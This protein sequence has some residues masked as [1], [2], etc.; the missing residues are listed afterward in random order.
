MNLPT[1][2]LTLGGIASL[3]VAVLHVVLAIRPQL[4]RYSGADQLAEL[5]EKGSKFVMPVTIGLV[6]MFAGWGAYGFSGAGV[7]GQLPLLKTVLVA[8]GVLYMFGSLNLASAFFRTLG[9]GHAP[10]FAIFSLG[11]LAFGLLHLIGTLVQ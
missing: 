9:S 4:Y 2:C 8:I 10:H 3:L 5:A 1:Y 6:L 11:A 7:I